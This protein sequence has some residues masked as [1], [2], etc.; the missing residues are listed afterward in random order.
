MSYLL[1]F[2]LT[3]IKT[4]DLRSSRML[5]SICWYLFT[6]VSGQA[7]RVIF[8]GQAVQETLTLKEGTDTVPETSI[9]SN[10]HTLRNIPEGR[11]PR[12]S[13][14]FERED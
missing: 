1:I 13:N 3:N 12:H 10:Q 5:R 4:G 8:K 9:N 14:I 7:M 2:P 11:R 6:D